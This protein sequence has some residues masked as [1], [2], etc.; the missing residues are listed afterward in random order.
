[1]AGRALPSGVGDPAQ[2]SRKLNPGRQKIAEAAAGEIDR[3][4]I[5]QGKP[6]QVEGIPELS[7][8]ILRR[9]E[10]QPTDASRHYLH[11]ALEQDTESMRKHPPPETRATGA[12]PLTDRKKRIDFQRGS[13]GLRGCKPAG[14]TRP[15]RGPQRYPGR[16]RLSPQNLGEE[17]ITALQKAEIASR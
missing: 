15:R 1:M 7:A 9:R 10:P 3:R 12:C 2:H 4:C 8:D 17:A 16:R 14:Q 5:R 11:H 6:L 13:S